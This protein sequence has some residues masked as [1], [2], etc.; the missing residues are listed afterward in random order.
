MGNYIEHKDRIAFHPGYYIEECLENSGLTQQDFADKLGMTSESLDELINGQESI[1]A[2]TGK[3]LSKMLGT[4]LEY[5][6]NLQ[7]AYDAALA[8]IHA[9]G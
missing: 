8:Q 1:S 3:K 4:S 7:G 9:E 2:E 5:W 6:F